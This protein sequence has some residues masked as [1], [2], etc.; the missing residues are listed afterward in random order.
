MTSRIMNDNSLA[1]LRKPKE[2][3]EGYGHRYTIPQEKID[4]LFSYIAD[5]MTIKAAAKE[6]NIC[7]VTAKK[8]F[9]QG[10]VK[11]GIKPLQM[12]LE[13]FQEKISEQMNV[14]L[15][16]QRMARIKTVRKLIEKAEEKLLG[17]YDKEGNVITEGDIGKCSTRDLERL[18]KLET[19]LTGT[20]KTTDTE[21][22][23]L[24]ADEIG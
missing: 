2:K 5:G 12:R 3:K 10:D 9:K 18:I 6:A 21:K 23:L 22:K 19:F 14:L 24:T 15:E 1:N 4:E 8:Y 20:I 11:R 16:E 7:F 17:K 13:V